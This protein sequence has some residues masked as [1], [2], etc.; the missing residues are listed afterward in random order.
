MVGIVIVSHS[1]KIAG[2]IKDLIE[3][4]TQGRV[5]VEVAAGAVDGSLGT[6]ATAITA[7]IQRA[8]TGEGVAVLMDLGSA[9]LS[10]ETALDLLPLE[11]RKRA[12]LCDAPL[13]EG[14]VAAGVEASLGS[15]LAEVR[16][17]AEMSRSLT[18]LGG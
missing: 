17:A 2:G 11:A 4:L 13:V 16:Q 1:G 5:R 9:V 18:K 6:D 3:Q 8:D 7:A 15:D 10:A 12:L 14:A